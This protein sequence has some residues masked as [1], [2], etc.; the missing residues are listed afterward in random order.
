AGLE[1]ARELPGARLVLV[2][3]QEADVPAA[4][5]EVGQELEQV[6]LGAGDPRHLLDVE[7][8]HAR[9]TSA[10]RSAQC[11]T[12]CRSSTTARSRRPIASRSAPARARSF[13]ASSSASPRSK[14]SS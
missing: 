12:E 2:Q 1:L 6:R 5:L 10:T 14:R 13:A 9:T 11:S 8:D 3:H 4:A 7:D